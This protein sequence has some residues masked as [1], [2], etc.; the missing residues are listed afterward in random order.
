MN[1]EHVAYFQTIL[2]RALPT[3]FIPEHSG[4]E[5]RGVEC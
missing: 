1:E 5:E 3:S 2:M 4:K